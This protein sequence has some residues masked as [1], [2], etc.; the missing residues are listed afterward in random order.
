MTEETY[1]IR[2]LGFSEPQK[3]L[4]FS[5]DAFFPSDELQHLIILSQLYCQAVAYG[6]FKTK[7]NQTFSSKVVTFAAPF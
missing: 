5:E 3:Y 1:A 4:I 6:R 2:H 7:K